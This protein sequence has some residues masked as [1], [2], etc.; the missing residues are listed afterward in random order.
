MSWNVVDVVDVLDG[1]GVVDEVEL[2]CR[3]TLTVVANTTGDG[4]TETQIPIPPPE[5]KTSDDE[6]EPEFRPRWPRCRHQALPTTGQGLRLA[7]H[8][9]DG[10]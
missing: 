7:L 4:R 6:E 8:G 3:A 2:V 9:F 1:V 10:R 5:A